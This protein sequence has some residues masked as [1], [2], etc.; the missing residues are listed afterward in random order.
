M[1]Q[2][3][4]E[5]RT[6]CVCICYNSDA[7][8]VDPIVSELTQ[9]RDWKPVICHHALEA[10]VELALRER[11]QIARS[12]WGLLRNESLVMVIS[13]SW[14]EVHAKECL[15]L[16]RAVRRYLPGVALLLQ[17][18]EE[19]LAIDPTSHDDGHQLSRLNP[20]NSGERN[21]NQIHPNTQNGRGVTVTRD[22]LDMLL[23]IADGDD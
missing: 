23:E 18:G 4:A 3:N 15:Q 5:T 16:I 22:E 11:E 9:V 20:L 12:E 10:M 2:R 1:A 21:G 7:D 6:T 13:S 14:A 17:K 8:Q 19:L